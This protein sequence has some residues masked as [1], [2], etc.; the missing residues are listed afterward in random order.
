MFELISLVVALASR[1]SAELMKSE[2]QAS[3]VP[4]SQSPCSFAPLILLVAIELAITKKWEEAEE[5]EEEAVEA[6]VPT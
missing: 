5:E 3:P 1:I 6:C 2:K 4:R